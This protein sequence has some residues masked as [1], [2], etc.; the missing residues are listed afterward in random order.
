MES[1]PK[2]LEKTLDSS[3]ESLLVCDSA[4]TIVGVNESLCLLTG[5][6]REDLLSRKIGDLAGAEAGPLL[7]G[8]SGGASIDLETG[9][10]FKDGSTK[11]LELRVRLVRLGGRPLS[12]VRLARRRRAADRLPENPAFVRALL[13]ASGMFVVC[14]CPEGKIVLANSLFE[15][16]V[17]APFVH[18]RGRALWDFVPDPEERD[19][20]RRRLGSSEDLR[21]FECL[22]TAPEDAR[23]KIA[24]SGTRLAAVPPAPPYLL[25]IG[26]D[27][28]RPSEGTRRFLARRSPSEDPRRRDLE[29]R[30]EELTRELAKARN[31]QEALTY[32]IA[33]DFKAPLRAMSG[34]SDALL[35][36]FAETP[37]DPEGQD[38]AARIGSSARQMDALIENLLLYSRLSHMPVRLEPQPLHAALTEVVGSFDREIRERGAGVS[39]DVPSV[40][41][42]ADRSVLFVLLYHLVSNALKFVL[43]GQEPRIALRAEPRKEFI[44]LSVEDN[45]IGIPAE[46]H[47]LIFK[48]GERLHPSDVYRGTGMGL[49]IVGKAA[50]RLRGRVGLR[51]CAGEGSCFWVDL[52]APVPA[53]PPGGGM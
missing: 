16:L 1:M 23:R 33:H 31:D 51:S 48:L 43:P 18:L 6:D 53:L 4:G 14:V 40:H 45:G 42:L 15:E 7:A 34:L 20:F 10:R 36:S 11:R 19:A 32:A 37:P 29:E 21:M 47:H 50:E 30:I 2:D 35:E 13:Q 49:A 17:G 41:V 38:Y 26:R 8:L 46:Y 5:Y 27:L 22:W 52:P 44:R 3:A 12:M 24:W 9:V 28:P 39:I 25:L